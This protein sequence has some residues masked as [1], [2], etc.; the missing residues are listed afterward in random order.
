MGMGSMWPLAARLRRTRWHLHLG[1]AHDHVR[2]KLLFAFT[3][4]GEHTVKNIAR[5]I[6]IYSLSAN[7]VASLPHAP[8]LPITTPSPNKRAGDLRR[9]RQVLAALV[10]VALIASGQ[11][12]CYQNRTT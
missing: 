6:R 5:P 8:L 10:A 12:I 11:M 3:D 4:L 9:G 1:D 2:D 7:T